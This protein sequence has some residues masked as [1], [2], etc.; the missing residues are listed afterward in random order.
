MYNQGGTDGPTMYI[1]TP[2]N[3]YYANTVVNRVCITKAITVCS[4]N[5]PDKTI[6]Q[7]KAGANGGNDVDTVRGAF[8]LNGASLVGFNIIAGHTKATGSD[9]HF[10]RS[11]GGVWL[12]ENCTVSN[13]ILTANSASYK[14]GGAYVYLGGLVSNCVLANNSAGDGGGAATKGLGILN[15]CILKG[16]SG[17]TGAGVHMS[18]G[19]LNNCLVTGNIASF[20]GAGV[21]VSSYG[22]LNNCTLSGNLADVRCG[23]AYLYRGG[24]VRNSI[25][26]GNSA[27]SANNI[28]T[29]SYGWSVNFTCSDPV[30]QFGTGNF[31][32]D[33][34]FLAE[35]HGDFRLRASSPC[36]DIGNNSYISTDS[37]LTGDQRIRNVTV[38]LGAY[39]FRQNE[40]ELT[41]TNGLDALQW[42]S[43]PGRIYSIY[44]TDN[45][46]EGFRPLAEN[47]PWTSNRFLNLPKTS[48]AF[49]K[50]SVELE[51][52]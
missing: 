29:Y 14:G 36:L 34:S 38:D 26:W 32:E 39:E 27:P 40:F 7:G 4:L 47:I 37:D 42:S 23:G 20:G 9:Y 21:Y 17:Y 31:C 35:D 16:N 19:T 12:S 48:S 50:L 52:K 45:L 18:G 6:I 25:V 13:C 11:G 15:N 41:Y 30:A 2:L 22:T 33:P 51:N 3:T 44:W 5:G 49:F 28:Y 43:G 24:S 1:G 10:D 8:L 46:S